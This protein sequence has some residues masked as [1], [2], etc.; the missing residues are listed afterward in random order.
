M[1]A[2]SG[3]GPIARLRA[4][5]RALRQAAL[6]EG[7]EPDGLLGRWVEAQDQALMAQAAVAEH[8]ELLVSEVLVGLERAGEAQ[9]ARLSSVLEAAERTDRMLARKAEMVAREAIG[10]VAPRPVTGVAK[11]P[12]VRDPRL[13]DGMR[14]GAVLASCALALLAAGYLFR[15]RQDRAA[16]A[17]A[18][19]D[20]R[21]IQRCA[22]ASP[23]A[24][25]QGNR[26]CYLAD[27]LPPGTPVPPM[28]QILVP[29]S[30]PPAPPPA[31]APSRPSSSGFRM[32]RPGEPV[33][34]D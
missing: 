23:L 31:P 24:D 33:R 7:I 1:A 3:E 5:A 22:D 14:R 6:A 10:A 17:L 12:M 32:V 26:A 25:S 8:Q 27:L 30:S 13:G 19:W 15:M 28:P 11:A 4:T 18:A 20:G 29:P 2:V 34:F 16:L 9:L 21:A